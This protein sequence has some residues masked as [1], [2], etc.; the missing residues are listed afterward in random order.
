M[1]NIVQIKKNIILERDETLFINMESFILE[2]EHRKPLNK[3]LDLLLNDYQK[4]NLLLYG[5]TINCLYTKEY[6][7]LKNEQFEEYKNCI[8]EEIFFYLTYIEQIPMIS[9]VYLAPE[10]NK[11]NMIHLHLLIG[12]KSILGF[13]DTIEKTLLEYLI[14]RNNY[15][16]FDIKVDKLKTWVDQ[17]K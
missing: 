9:F 12:L 8:Q 11:N 5:I 14:K 7:K 13:N 1:G 6:I 2:K 16:E 4:N 15:L 3:L 17:K 10:K